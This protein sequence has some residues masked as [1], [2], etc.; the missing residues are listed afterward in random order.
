MESGKVKIDKIIEK[1][2]ECDKAAGLSTDMMG[3]DL[4]ALGLMMNK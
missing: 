1:I 2:R 4:K 3:L